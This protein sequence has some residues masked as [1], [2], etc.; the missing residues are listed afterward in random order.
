MQALQEG[1]LTPRG[2]DPEVESHCLRLNKTLA[3]R[4]LRF[5]KEKSWGKQPTKVLS[6]FLI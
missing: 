2:Q 1:Y 6:K 5:T 4:L 3:R